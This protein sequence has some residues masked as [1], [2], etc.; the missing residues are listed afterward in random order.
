MKYEYK[1]TVEQGNVYIDS[2]DVEK[3]I[4]LQYAIES[5]DDAFSIFE[6][7]RRDAI[8][9]DTTCVAF[10]FGLKSLGFAMISNRDSAL[11]QKLMPH[12]T[13]F[14]KEMKKELYH[15]KPTS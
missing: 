10:V 1:M 2:D 11:V 9:D 6:G 14:M 3:N 8:F 4:S 12:F 13:S 5:N 15:I 7:L